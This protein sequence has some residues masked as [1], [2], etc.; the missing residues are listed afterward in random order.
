MQYV[1]REWYQDIIKNQLPNI[2]G[3]VGPMSSL[4]QL[5]RGVK[6]LFW[7]PVDQYK[8]DGRIVRGVQRG[9]SSFIT[10]TTMSMLE[11]TNKLVGTI[12]SAAEV[13]YDIVSPGPGVRTRTHKR[14][15]RRLI[16]PGDLRE[17]VTNAV[18]IVKEG[19]KGTAKNLYDVA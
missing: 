8:K 1:V 9:A 6:N 18:V 2:L 13:T 10:L 19:F 17:G 16:H 15:H 11:L 3:G 5:V 12:Q 4:V 14:Y 7:L